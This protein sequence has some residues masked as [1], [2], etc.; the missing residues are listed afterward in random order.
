MCRKAHNEDKTKF[1]YLNV[2]IDVR[3]Q[4][5]FARY[6]EA[7]PAV[8]ARFGGRSLVKVGA[9]HPIEGV[10]ETKRLI[11]IEFPSIEA[12]RVFYQRPEYAPLLKLKLEST[13][14]K[15]ML[16]EGWVAPA[17]SGTPANV[18]PHFFSSTCPLQMR[19]AGDENFVP[20]R[21]C[22]P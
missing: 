14:S 15:M 20:D 9:L 3:D 1:A 13:P 4:K 16:V 5:G 12:T 22:R 8:V 19:W 17:R 2:D 11:L 10:F 6:R 18:R 7:F 21:R